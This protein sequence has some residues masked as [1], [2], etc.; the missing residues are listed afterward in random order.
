MA[1]KDAK[2]YKKGNRWQRTVY[3]A[4]AAHLEQLSVTDFGASSAGN[5]Y[6]HLLK[7]EDS[8]LNFMSDEIYEATIRRFSTHKAGDLKRIMT[9]TA[10]SQPYCFNLFAHLSLHLP[11]ASGLFSALLRKAV[12]VQHIAVEFTPNHL[13]NLAGFEQTDEDESIGDQGVRSGTD[14]DVAVFY[15]F[16]NDQK[17][18][19]LIEFKFIEPEFSVCGSYKTKTDLAGICMQK[20][21]FATMVAGKATD[22]KGRVLCGYNKYNN[23]LL[24]AN[25]TLFNRAA[26]EQ[27]VT[28][29]P[30][31][32]GGN[33]L[34]RNMLLA[35][36][37][38]KAR[39]CDAFG[40]WVLS[41]KPNDNY[42]W[43]DHGGDVEQQ[44]R[45]VLSPKGRECFRRVH[46]EYIVALLK[47]L[48]I[49]DADSQWLQRLN[50]K[51]LITSV[52]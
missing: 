4:M 24:T 48:C 1:E 49:S 39:N 36:K 47:K 37:V 45:N 40:F 31:R 42:L 30:F 44:F 16:G 21:Y 28:G 14:A 38:A 15:T 51:Y 9:N 5:N 43:Q 8:R 23:W 34:W 27:S 18:V 11:L 26:I 25:S 13:R 50:E 46:L 19:L 33:Q 3:A 17:G 7:E 6:K 41:P 12:T 32:L 2:I 29:C 10:A 52:V 22:D 35:E 20:G